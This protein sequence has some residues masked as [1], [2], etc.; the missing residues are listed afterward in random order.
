MPSSVWWLWDTK[1]GKTLNEAPLAS[2]SNERK[3]DSRNGSKKERMLNLNYMA[4]AP[5]ALVS[6]V[7]VR[8]QLRTRAKAFIRCIFTVLME[9]CPDLFKDAPLKESKMLIRKEAFQPWKFQRTIDL[10]ASSVNCESC[11]NLRAGVEEL[12]KWEVGLMP[13]AF[14]I[15]NAAK[16]LEQCAV[17][18]H[19]LVI[20]EESNRHGISHWFG[21]DTQIRMTL[22]GF[23]LSQW[24][25]TG[26]GDSPVLLCH[27][28]DGA[29]LTMCLGHVTAGVKIVDPRAVDPITRMLLVL[30]QSRDLC[31]PCQIVFG[32]DCKDL[33]EDCFGAF[34]SHFNN[35]VATPAIPELGLPELSNFKVVSPQ[36]LSSLWKCTGRGCATGNGK[37]TEICFVCMCRSDGRGVSKVLADR[38]SICSGLGLERCYCHPVN[39]MQQIQET[40]EVMEQCVSTVLDGGY[41]KL[42]AIKS[43]SKILSDPKQANREEHRMHTEY[44]P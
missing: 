25:E 24:A 34:H 2:V 42:D 11:G 4:D 15:K 23:G 38:C 14:C 16:E 13:S 7:H 26:S 9:T 32:R 8:R 21:L 39:D 5:W 6:F 40:R 3:K 12:D 1:E 20:N 10:T 18:A 41:K 33:C 31:F 17:D 36:D 30:L 43:K 19:G 35:G 44:E 22:D 37:R 29:Q 27:T 28:L